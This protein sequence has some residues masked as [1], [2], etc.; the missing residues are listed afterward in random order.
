MANMLLFSFIRWI[1]PLYVQA[2]PIRVRP[3]VVDESYRQKLEE[4]LAT[5]PTE[6]KVYS[7]SR[8]STRLM[9]YLEQVTG[10]DVCKRIFGSVLA[11]QTYVY[12]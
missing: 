3:K 6:L 10:I 1:L 2:K 9:A 7:L 11:E 8:N 12:R 5:K 4:T